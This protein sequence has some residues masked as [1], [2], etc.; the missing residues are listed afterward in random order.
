M[1][2]KVIRFALVLIA[3]LGFPDFSSA[4]GG[5]VVETDKIGESADQRAI[6]VRNGSSI[7]LT[8]STAYNAERAKFS[9]VSGTGRRN[10]QAGALRKRS[11]ET[12]TIYKSPRI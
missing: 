11:F 10:A 7:S 9:R 2:G 8:L 4:D 1:K 5:V 3:A 6:L 12:N